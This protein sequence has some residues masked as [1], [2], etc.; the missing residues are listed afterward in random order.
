MRGL[1]YPAAGARGGRVPPADPQR[2]AIRAR[3][4]LRPAGEVTYATAFVLWVVQANRAAR[5]REEEIAPFAGAVARA[6]R[7]V[8]AGVCG[9]RRGLRGFLSG[10]PRWRC[11]I[12]YGVRAM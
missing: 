5:V 11:S 1:E 2:R 6:P 3:D 4:C 12:Y 9:V 7:E 8:A 10:V